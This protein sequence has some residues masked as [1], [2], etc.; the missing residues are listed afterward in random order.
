MKQSSVRLVVAGQPSPEHSASG[1][2]AKVERARSDRAAVHAHLHQVTR[3][4][5]EHQQEMTSLNKQLRFI[6]Q[7]SAVY[8]VTPDI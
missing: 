5:T 6:L 4:A 1:R 3:V 8:A 2:E 7:G